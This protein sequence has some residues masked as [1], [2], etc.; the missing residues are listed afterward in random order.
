MYRVKP[1]IMRLSKLLFTLILLLSHQVFWAQSSLCALVF[2]EGKPLPQAKVY[3]VDEFGMQSFHLTDST[4]LVI[5]NGLSSGTYDLKIGHQD[6]AGIQSFN[7][8][9]MPA[10]IF[11]LETFDLGVGD[12]SYVMED[13]KWEKV[14]EEPYSYDPVAAPMEE[15]MAIETLTGAPVVA[16][17]A[18]KRG[19]K[20]KSVPSTYDV[21]AVGYMDTEPEGIPVES[22]VPTDDPSSNQ[23]IQAGTL[24]ASEWNDLANWDLWSDQVEE[25]FAEF[26]DIWS[27]KPI[28]RQTILLYNEQGLPLVHAYIELI[29]EDGTRLSAGRTDNKG[30]A[31]LFLKT[32]NS[33]R[34]ACRVTYNGMSFEFP[35]IKAN[36]KLE[37]Q[38]NTACSTNAVV[39]IMFVVDATG[40]MG[41]E[42]NY[43]KKEVE[44]V[45]DRVGKLDDQKTI[46]SGAIF[47]RDHQDQ[48]LSRRKALSTDLSALNTFV[49]DQRAAGGG[50]FPEAIDVALEELTTSINWSKNA[51][52]KI[53]FIILD[54][55]P[56]QDS[57]S[58]ERVN[59]SVLKAAEL[60]IRL[61]PITGSGIDKNTEYLMK[62]LAIQTNG[63][64]LYL[65]DDSGVGGKHLDASNDKTEV[66]PLNDLMVKVVDSMI[67]VACFEP[68]EESDITA[69][70]T[71]TSLEGVQL[72]PNPMVDVLNINVAFDVDQVQI[73]DLTGQVMLDLGV[74]KAGS[75]QIDVSRLKAGNYLIVFRTGDQMNSLKLI[76]VNEY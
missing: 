45:I 73:F 33:N 70:E 50:D 64:Y 1:K 54:A 2:Q 65:T 9:L 43:L 39:D 53:A 13:G 36:E 35:N 10:G 68:N 62:A 15:S 49:Q 37:I 21:D 46:R 25:E 55:P 42:I 19:R 3:L 24:T 38:V 18:K 8:L 72:F 59:R 63:T 74:L 51:M 34:F 75:H 41:D 52:A 27:F 17:K 5:I 67:E 31:E 69:T 20:D 6:L 71:N 11:K 44:D 22:I 40:S 57:A 48:Y 14:K 58:I 23:D 30:V 32:A 76:S 60:G 29:G 47:Y 28:N 56:H 7:D 12:A 4:G 66:L 61:I 16:S 26:A